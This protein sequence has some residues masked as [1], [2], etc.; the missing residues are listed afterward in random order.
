MIGSNRKADGSKMP[1]TYSMSNLESKSN[2]KLPERSE[3][4]I[5][6]AQKESGRGVRNFFRNLIHNNRFKSTGR[7]NDE[8]REEKR[9]EKVIKEYVIIEKTDLDHRFLTVKNKDSS[10]FKDY[11]NTQLI[12]NLD[13]LKYLY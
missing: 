11:I 10:L 12:S 9:E 2:G 7:K 8:A 13:E 6:E 3:E 1:K 5:V 4:N